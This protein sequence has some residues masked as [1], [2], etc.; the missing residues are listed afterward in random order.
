MLGSEFEICVLKEQLTRFIF[1]HLYNKP[2]VPEAYSRDIIK[3]ILSLSHT[4]TII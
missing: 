3:K 1:R 4:T 2:A